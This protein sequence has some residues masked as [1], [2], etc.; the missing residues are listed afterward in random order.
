MGLDWNPA[1]KPVPGREQEYEILRAALEA[2]AENSDEESDEESEASRRFFAA[3][4][5]AFDTL[6]A[7]TIGVDEIADAWA[8]EQYLDG[9]RTEPFE[10]WFDKV[11]GLRLVHL[12]PECPGIPRYSNG[13]P[14]GY[15]EPFSFRAQFLTL[16][17]DIIGS[18]VLEQCFENKQA[19]ELVAF[20]RFLKTTGLE[21]AAAQ[22]VVVPPL[23]DEF[24]E[25]SPEWRADIL[26]AAGEWC[27]YW[28]ERGHPLEAYW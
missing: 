18:E 20:G 19:D 7:P 11:R 26:V 8:R 12:V 25:N 21:Y 27:I 3:T 4:I 23:S 24:D 5:S 1:N 10:V 6:N 2:E 22:N 16:C 14:A 28:G 13:S 9:E 17:E 15:V